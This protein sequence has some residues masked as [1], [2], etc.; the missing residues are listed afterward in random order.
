MQPFSVCEVFI[1]SQ[2]STIRG[3]MFTCRVTSL[4]TSI[5]F[6]LCI[7]WYKFCIYW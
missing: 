5:Q 6:W 2:T 3:V 7:N 4:I 1:S